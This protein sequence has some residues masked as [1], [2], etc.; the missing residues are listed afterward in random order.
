MI[1]LAN[2]NDILEIM[3]V[4][5]RVKDVMINIDNIPQWDES[6]PNKDVFLEDIKNN[7]MY[8]YIMDN[9][10]A[11]Y[12]VLNNEEDIIEAN[13]VN[14]RKYDTYKVIHRFAV[15]PNFQNKGIA[16]KLVEHTFNVA[17]EENLEAIRI[18]TNSYNEKMCSLILKLGFEHRG[19]MQLRKNRPIW[20][21]YDI[22]L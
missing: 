2:T 14:Y 8:V 22:I 11:G 15:D 13:K 3:E 12:I 1:R 21:A 10:I 17:K 9:K 16:T 4:T 6:Y 19:Y 18:D 7:T 20:H 5:N